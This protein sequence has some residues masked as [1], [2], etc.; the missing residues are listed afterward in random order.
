RELPWRR[1]PERTQRTGSPRLIELAFAAARPCRAPHPVET[2]S[3]M[4][5]CTSR[6]H[7]TF[8]KLTLSW[9]DRASLPAI[10]YFLKVFPRQTMGTFVPLFELLTYYLSFRQSYGSRPRNSL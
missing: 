7:P 1:F 3:R 2:R 10:C 8:D 4:S 9:S 6:Y 5:I